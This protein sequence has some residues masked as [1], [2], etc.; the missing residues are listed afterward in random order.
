MRVGG[1]E[2][3]ESLS[4]PHV[5]SINSFEESIILRPFFA[6]WVSS[7]N[8]ENRFGN[9][10]LCLQ[11]LLSNKKE[12]RKQTKGKLICMNLP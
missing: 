1:G 7:K 4:H 8:L 11:C 9:A 5:T 3:T 6:V 10:K 2:S 12:K